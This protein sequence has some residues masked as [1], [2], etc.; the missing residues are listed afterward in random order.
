MEE[1]EE[2]RGD[3]HRL[4]VAAGGRFAVGWRQPLI[5]VVGVVVRKSKGLR[6]KRE[7][8]E[9]GVKCDDVLFEN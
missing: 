1:R 5:G 6:E 8:T 7:W 2:V 4:L 3:S 9:V